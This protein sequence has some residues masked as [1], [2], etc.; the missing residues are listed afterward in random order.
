MEAADIKGLL[1][2]LLVD[3]S[4]NQYRTP[5]GGYVQLTL[6]GGVTEAGFLSEK[7]DEFRQFVPTKAEIVPYKTAARFSRRRDKTGL[8]DNDPRHTTVLRFRVSTNKLRPVYNLLYPDGSRAITQSVLDMLGAPAAAWTWAEG[9]RNFNDGTAQL[10]R[11]GTTEAEAERISRWLELLTGAKSTGPVLLGEGYGTTKGGCFV[12]PR[13][14]FDAENAKKLRSALYPYAPIT[15]KH[16]FDDCSV[17]ED[18]S[19]LVSEQG[20]A[21]PAR[22]QAAAMA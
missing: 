5:R 16:V 21:E 9:G 14:S 13:L 22:E 10:A 2:L 3:G 20:A 18:S 12:K 7:V 15:R 1:G 17:H 6:T 8:I 4:L 11:C 19:G